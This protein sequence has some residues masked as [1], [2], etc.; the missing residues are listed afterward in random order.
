MTK[1]L[2]TYSYK[3]SEERDLLQKKDKN[4]FK[5]KDEEKNFNNC[6]LEKFFLTKKNF[7]LKSEISK[8][9][10]ICKDEYSTKKA[11]NQI[12]PIINYYYNNNFS[13]HKY[14]KYPDTEQR[15]LAH[16]NYDYNT[17]EINNENKNVNNP[18]VNKVQIIEKDKINSFLI[19]NVN[20]NIDVNNY[21]S[22]KLYFNINYTYYNCINTPILI[23][24]DKFG[25]IAMTNKIASDQKYANEILFPLIKN[26]LKDLCCDNLG[27]YF[28]QTFLDIITFDNLNEFL[29][30]ISKDF[31]DICLSP[32]G[33]RIIQ[34][35][36]DKISF[37]PILIN[38][39][40]FILNNDNLG[41]ICKSPYGN[42]FIQKFIL[43]F[44]SSEYTF[45]IFNYIYRN[46]IDIANSKH[47]VF[48][49]QKCISEGYTIQREK[50]YNLILFN[51]MDLIQNE[52]GNY[53]IQFILLN[54]QNIQQT[55]Q[56]IMPILLKIEENLINFCTSKYPASVLEKCFENSDNMIRNHIL[57]YLFNNC[58]NKILDIFFNNHG[59]YV[60]LKASITQNGKYKNKLISVF[61]ENVDN[62]KK[63]LTFNS[64]K[65]KKIL[66][67]ARK[68]K[69][70]EDI[71]KII[72]NNND[73]N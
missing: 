36:I 48:I 38:K 56:Q 1:F 26:N 19:N 25:C 32:Q 12:N 6:S 58:S 54:K 3:D 51:L 73:D 64:K 67:L 18:D 63:E 52:F 16:N 53:L 31:F 11:I 37:T 14:P 66:K 9:I 72:E 20:N 47:G 2:E 21:Y 68:Y 5:N 33:S 42:H 10:I 15:N 46:F 34:K 59:I 57:E 45:F 4:L 7:I 62:L 43:T 24:K 70:L 35:L 30:L 23:I 13:Y 44:H 50:I 29:D 71:C 55:F 61:N 22:H 8:S 27:N 17:P 41:S 28:L 49:I 40:I 60:I 39:F 69:D 65:C